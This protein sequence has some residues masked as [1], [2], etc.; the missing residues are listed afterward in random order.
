MSEKFIIPKEILY[1][2]SKN[3]IEE[4][5]ERILNSP[6]TKDKVLANFFG[7]DK[8]VLSDQEQENFRLFGK[9]AL[10]RI[11]NATLQ[12]YGIEKGKGS[13]YIQEK[14]TERDALFALHDIT[15]SIAAYQKSSEDGTLSVVPV[16]HKTKEDAE[17]NNVTLIKEELRTFIW[18]GPFVGGSRPITL[19][20]LGD[21]SRKLLIEGLSLNY[22]T[23]FP[24]LTQRM[25]SSIEKM[26]QDSFDSYVATYK[27]IVLS[28]T[29]IP[30][31]YAIRSQNTDEKIIRNLENEFTTIIEKLK[32]SPDPKLNEIL[33][34][35]YSNQ[36]DPKILYKEF[37]RICGPLI[38]NL[39]QRK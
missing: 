24:E 36:G 30:N 12:K 28:L 23:N 32:L 8:G 33:Q 11:L 27:D 35:I 13:E 7:V 15:H 3:E 37:Y 17:V 39:K 20:L 22:G 18:N 21:E 1:K 10:K 4:M 34:T 14:N 16:F 9:Y 2:E 31:T 25:I 29:E 26:D 38:E 6:E 5:A 19:E